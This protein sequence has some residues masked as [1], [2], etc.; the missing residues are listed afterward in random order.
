M[1]APAPIAIK[2]WAKTYDIGQAIA[3]A[4]AVLTSLATGYVAYSCKLQLP[5]LL[6]M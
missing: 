3:P 2:Q 5:L 6:A 4:I 1:L